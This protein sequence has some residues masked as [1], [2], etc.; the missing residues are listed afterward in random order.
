MKAIVQAA[1]GTA[2]ALR[3]ADVDVPV[4]GPDGVLVRVHAASVHAGD[5]HMTTGLP[6][7]ARP[8]IGWRGPRAR[9]RG[10]DVAGVVEAVGEQVSAFRPGEAVF[11]VASGGFAEYAVAP[12]RL[13]APVPDGVSFAQAA[14]V[15]TSGCTALD[16][17]RGRIAPG[18]RVLVTGAGGGVGTF[19]V[20]LA[21]AAGAHVTGVCGPRN[22]E[23]VL[24]NGANEVIDYTR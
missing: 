9:V 4:P 13:L 3:F 2:A 7:L 12:T 5:V 18:T 20:A 10:S 24:A 11:G 15:P 16:A 23:R 8:V 19:V 1:Y 21:K 6:M 17:V 22:L 14:A